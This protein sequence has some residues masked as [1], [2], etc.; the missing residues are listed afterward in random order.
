[1]SELS[2]VKDSAMNGI[3]PSYPKLQCT[4]RR[5]L[6]VQLPIS[7]YHLLNFATRWLQA[8][9]LNTM[10]RTIRGEKRNPGGDG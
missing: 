2:A 3:F 5:L 7:K 8:H 6:R 9:G 1:M 4:N 10:K